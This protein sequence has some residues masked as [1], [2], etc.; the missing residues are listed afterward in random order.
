MAK[1]RKIRLVINETDPVPL[2]K[3]F[4]TFVSYLAEN[5]PYL[6]KKKQFL[7]PKVVYHI[8]H[9]MS[10][11]NKENTPRTGQELYPLLHL[12]YYLVFYGKLFKKVF[13]G[14]QK[15]KMQ[16]ID[17]IKEYLHLTPPEKYFFL[18]ETFWVDCDWNKLG[19]R[20]RVEYII[21]R[22]TS[23]LKFI[24]KRNPGETISPKEL[25][26][27][28]FP[29]FPMFD[30]FFMLYLSFFGFFKLT[31]DEKLYK[32][33][34][35]KKYFPISSLTPS[36]LGVTLAP[37]LCKERPLEKWNLSFRQ[38]I[39]GKILS[40]PGLELNQQNEKRYVPFFKAFTDFFQ[41]GELQKTLSRKPRKLSRGTF[42]FKVSVGKGI[43]RKIAISGECTLED[44]HV[45]IQDAFHFDFDHLYAFFMDGEP[46]S[47]DAIYALG[48]E[49]GPYVDEIRIGEMEL[50]VGEQF[51]YLFDFGD[52]WDFEVRL[53]EIK[54]EY[55]KPSKPKVVESKGEA[56]EQYPYMEDE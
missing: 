6:T 23:V 38:K 28:E 3:D 2:V 13:E 45:A 40:F 55:P 4:D 11:P 16:K 5:Q 51:L 54:K 14:S 34:Q 1:G 8:N 12:F 53:V 48:C 41:E 30:D 18:L 22:V 29:T 50:S 56:P 17:R 7:P 35:L 47:Y 37:I 33:F 26:E 27:R 19:V 46:W 36:L 49:E 44:L 20:V 25:D 32:E 31:R 21:W 42:I 52:E 24:A 43:W 15:I 10:K 39:E 9:L